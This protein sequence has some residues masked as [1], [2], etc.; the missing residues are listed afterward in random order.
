MNALRRLRQQD[1]EPIAF[2]ESASVEEPSVKELWS[3]GRQLSVDK[4][5]RHY[6]AVFA[7][8]GDVC[9]DLKTYVHMFDILREAIRGEWCLRT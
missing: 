4:Q 1:L 6:H 3:A 7:T 8:S 2:S 9:S 5:R